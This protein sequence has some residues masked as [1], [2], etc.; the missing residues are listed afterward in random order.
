[1]I[2]GKKL[3]SC[4]NNMLEKHVLIN[5]N[6]IKCSPTVTVKMGQLNWFRTVGLYYSTGF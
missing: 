5:V 3:Y 1:M 6:T 2:V 4:K